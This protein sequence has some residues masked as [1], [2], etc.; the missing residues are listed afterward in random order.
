VAT[1]VGERVDRVR[2]VNSLEDLALEADWVI[3]AALEDIDL[4][5]TI[6]RTL[7]D[8]A[9]DERIGLASNTSALSIAEIAAATI[10]PERVLGLHFF[11]PAPVMQLVEVIVGPETATDIADAASALVESWGKVA[12]RA[13]DRPGFIVNRVNRPFTLEALR[14]LES[15]RA[16]VQQIDAAVVAAGY[17]MGPFAFMDLVGLD[18]NLAAASAIFRAIGAE[19]LRPSALQRRLVEAGRLGRKAGHGFYRYNNGA[20]PIAESAESSGPD[21]QLSASEILERIE[22]AITNEAF[23]ALAEGVA[24]EPDID[25][26]MEL[27][28]NHPVGPIARAR[29]DGIPATR[30]RLQRLAASDG[31]RFLPAAG[32]ADGG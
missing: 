22:L 11:N 12:V 13:A 15:G 14:I 3:E 24:S 23:H 1:W 30:R 16:S 18:V 8:A 17:P 32:I 25:R 5:R 21:R 27:G 31:E 4:K 26:A 20:A 7:D 28:A 9:G 10:H 2:D 19:R 29:T 6:F